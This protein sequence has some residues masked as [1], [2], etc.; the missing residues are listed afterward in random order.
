MAD[1]ALGKAK[2][3]AEGITSKCGSFSFEK[4]DLSENFDVYFN[5]ASGKVVSNSQEVFPVKG[6]RRNPS[7]TYNVFTAAATNSGIDMKFKGLVD[8]DGTIKY[9]KLEE[10]PLKYLV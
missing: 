7:I 6:T 3:F 8:Q 1:T 9:F 5:E 2:Y 10:L 4:F